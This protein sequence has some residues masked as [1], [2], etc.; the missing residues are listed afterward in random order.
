MRLKVPFYKQTTST[1]CGP[2]ALQMVLSYFG[3][4]PGLD[5]VEEKVGIRERKAVSTIQL[6]IASGAFGF[7][8]RFLSKIL[9]FDEKH[10]ELDFYKKYKDTLVDHSELIAR[11]RDLGVEL[12]EKCVGLDEFLSYIGED[13]LVI[14][15]LDWNIVKGE[16]ER[17]YQGHFVVVT[18]WDEEN[19]YVHNHGFRDPMSNMTIPKEVFDEARKA[20]GT[21][22]DFVVVRKKK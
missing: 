21:D 4:D 13:S 14:V 16:K 20:Q 18:G 12:E 15:L 11:A 2:V 17:G 6:A 1:N 3:E 5:V 19:V 22:E 8:T 9:G 7:G 10:M